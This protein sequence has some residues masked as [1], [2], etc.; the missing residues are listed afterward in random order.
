MRA[1]RLLL[2]MPGL[3]AAALAL[4]AC[5]VARPGAVQAASAEEFNDPLEEINRTIFG[6]NQAVDQAVL[7]PA[8]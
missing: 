3:L 6:F 8:A 7:V 2:I 4:S 1:R 5:T